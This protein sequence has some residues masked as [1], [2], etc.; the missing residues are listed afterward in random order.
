M[1][2]VYTTFGRSLNLGKMHHYMTS[3]PD[4]RNASRSTTPSQIQLM[5]K[6]FPEIKERFTA[7]IHSA[8]SSMQAP[9]YRSSS[10]K[11]VIFAVEVGITYFKQ[12]ASG[13]EQASI[14]VYLFPIFNLDDRGD[15]NRYQIGRP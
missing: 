7:W 8:L 13:V 14:R 1:E 6:C 2:E 12:L 4:T 15:P 9:D 3:G 10:S 5:I 11:S